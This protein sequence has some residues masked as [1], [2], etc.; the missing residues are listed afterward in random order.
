M[1]FGFFRVAAAVPAVQTADPAFNLN[2][3][4]E[5][6]HSLESDGPSLVVMPEMSLSA[7]TLSLIHI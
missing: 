7:Y 2:A 4:I 3:A 6:L 5:S 1:N